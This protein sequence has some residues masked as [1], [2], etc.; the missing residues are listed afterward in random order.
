V[1]L[2]LGAL[3]LSVLAMR[4]IVS[5]WT[6]LLLALS[7]FLNLHVVQADPHSTGRS[8]SKRHR[9][10]RKK[11]PQDDE[12]PRN[13]YQ[14][15]NG[16]RRRRDGETIIV[17]EAR[18]EP[19]EPSRRRRRHDNDTVI[20]EEERDGYMDRESLLSGGGGRYEGKE[21]ERY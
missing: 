4:Y 3:S 9:K 19:L 13:E 12:E 20:V 11:K 1:P 2:T 17:E 18:K 16:R 14:E 8:S 15:Q 10:R 21:R 5:S 7:S 6:I